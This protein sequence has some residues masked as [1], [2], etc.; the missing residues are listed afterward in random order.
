M[1]RTRLVVLFAFAALGCQQRAGETD[2]PSAAPAPLPGDTMQHP[3]STPP[4]TSTG[5]RVVLDQD[6]YRSRGDVQLTLINETSRELG[7]NACTRVVERESAGTWTAVP[8]PDRVC[9][10]EIRSLA[11]NARVT[12]PTDLPALAPGRYRI[13]LRFF[14]EGGGGGPL[15]GVST[16]FTVQ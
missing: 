4:M 13:A 11:A 7:Y 2:T 9:T 14:D 10:M 5:V 6:T 3:S 8:E 16:P 15:R 1:S 12:E